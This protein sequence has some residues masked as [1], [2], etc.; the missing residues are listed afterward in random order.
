LPRRIGPHCPSEQV[1]QP[2]N[3][4]EY[5]VWHKNLWVFDSKAEDHQIWSQRF[6]F[7]LVELRDENNHVKNS[8]HR[9]TSHPSAKSIIPPA[10]LRASM[11]NMCGTIPLSVG[12]SIIAPRYISPKFRTLV[13][14]CFGSLWRETMNYELVQVEKPTSALRN[15][16]YF[17]KSRRVKRKMDIFLM[18]GRL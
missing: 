13:N 17:S 8:H 2:S 18:Q 12:L 6:K 5:T 16:F 10:V 15:L 14:W 7:S 4:T 11:L 3:F 9:S 1:D